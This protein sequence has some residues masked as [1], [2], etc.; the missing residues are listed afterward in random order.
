LQNFPVIT[1]A[2]AGSSST[3]VSG[4]LNSLANTHFVLDFY[5]SA[6]A[7]PS[8]YGEGQRWLGA[9]HVL[10]DAS[11]NASFNLVA[12]PGASTFGEW[13][14]A[15]ATRLAGSAD[16]RDTSEFS[17]AVQAVSPLG[18]RASESAVEGESG[19]PTAMQLI[20][21][22]GGISAQRIDVN[23]DD[24]VSPL[25]T[26]LIVNQ[27]NWFATQA[28]TFSLWH[29]QGYVDDRLEASND[30]LLSA[31][32]VLMAVNRL[33]QQTVT[34]SA[35]MARSADGTEP[36]TAAYCVR[37]SD[38]LAQHDLALLSVLARLEPMSIG[39]PQHGGK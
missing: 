29:E 11:G 17:S 22:D 8:G 15:T 3:V 7:D 1:F 30:N 27:L 31:F 37:A 18:F 35:A 9:I 23:R 39:N 19:S 13:I 24:V 34:G 26:L 21:N 6:A 12:L 36:A 14:T 32:D 5:A 38:A 28:E 2:Q 20:E 4:S 10:T 33:K 16:Y 25:D